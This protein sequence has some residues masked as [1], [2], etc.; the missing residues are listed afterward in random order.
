MRVGFMANG[1]EVEVRQVSL[2]VGPPL[3]SV[4]F[5]HWSLYHTRCMIIARD[6][7]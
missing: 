4:L 2:R 3:L 5:R 7:Q 6:V 1:V